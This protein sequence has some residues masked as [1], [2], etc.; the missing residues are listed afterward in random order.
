MINLKN[1]ITEK[2]D[3]KAE[4]FLDI[5][6]VVDSSIKDLKD[7]TVDATP[8]GNW[9]VFYKNKK[10]TVVNSNLLDEPIIRKYNLEHHD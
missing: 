2:L 8:K 6:Q 7:I 4:R 10:M 9:V 3:Y 1:L 5:I